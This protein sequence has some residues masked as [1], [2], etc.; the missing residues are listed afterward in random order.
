MIFKWQV[1][2][3]MANRQHKR[4]RCVL[5]QAA[6]WLGVSLALGGKHHMV[7]LRF[8]MHDALGFGCLRC[9]GIS[10]MFKYDRYDQKGPVWLCDGVF[11]LS[12]SFAMF[13]LKDCFAKESL[14]FIP[15]LRPSRGSH[16]SAKYLWIESDFS[17]GSS[18]I[19]SCTATPIARFSGKLSGAILSRG[20]VTFGGK[21][22]D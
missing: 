8:V 5:C 16:N 1:D 9:S 3:Y 6:P 22:C 10:V 15:C 13:A 14:G 7:S 20:M 19:E 4:N 12:R 2:I 21:H 11:T 18:S 17:R